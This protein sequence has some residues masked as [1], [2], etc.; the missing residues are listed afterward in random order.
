[1]QDVESRVRKIPAS[2]IGNTRLTQQ[3]SAHV[4]FL[5]PNYV[6][7]LFHFHGLGLRIEVNKSL[8]RH[9][10]NSICNRNAV[11]THKRLAAL[12]RLLTYS[13]GRKSLILILAN[14]QDEIRI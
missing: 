11:A 2:K 9:F 6:A 3:R 7:A 13:N 5:L 8:C 4:R 1:M 14:G 10:R 12:L